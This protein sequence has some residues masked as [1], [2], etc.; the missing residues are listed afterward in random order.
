MRQLT[1]TKKGRVEW[2]EVPEPRLTAPLQAIVHPLVAARCDR[3]CVPLFRSVTNLM[4]AGIALHLLDPLVANALGPKPFQGPFAF[5]PR[6]H[7]QGA[8]CWRRSAYGWRWRSSDCALG[9]LMWAMVSLP[10][11]PYRQVHAERKHDVLRLRIRFCNGILGRSCK[12]PA[13]CSLRGCDAI[14]GPYGAWNLY[15]LPVRATTFQM[16]IARSR[17]I[18]AGGRGLQCLS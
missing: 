14:A 10:K 18:C 6:M 17:R 1:F 7:R 2:Q 3:D 12:R 8:G 5:W 11:R 13:S 4:N 9:D 16:A 15:P